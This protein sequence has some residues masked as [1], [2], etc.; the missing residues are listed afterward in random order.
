MSDISNIIAEQG[1]MVTPY[2]LTDSTVDAGGAVIREWTA[3]NEFV[4]YLQ[5][6]MTS[7]PV[8]A[9]ARRTNSGARGYTSVANTLT[10]GMRIVYGSLTYEVLGFYT[11]DFRASPNAL[12]YQIV[13]LLSVGGVA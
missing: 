8:E 10:Q 11:P 12:A 3:G 9:G 1:V 2:T 13:D 5:P 6:R 4:M 7:E